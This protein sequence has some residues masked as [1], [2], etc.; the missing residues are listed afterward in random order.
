MSIDPTT[1][2]L[3]V[4]DVDGV[5]TDGRIIYDDAGGELKM[6]HVQDGSG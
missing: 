3:L 2:D 5:L 6:F 4:L 1:I